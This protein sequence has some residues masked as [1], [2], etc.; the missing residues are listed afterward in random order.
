MSRKSSSNAA[1]KNSSALT[2]GSSSTTAQGSSILKSSF[3]PSQFQLRLFASVIQ[4]FDSQQLRIHETT[5]G[6]LRC[7][8]ET[9]P[10]SRITSLDW[11]FNGRDQKQKKKRKRQ[12]NSEGAVVAYGTSTSDIC[13]FSPAEGKV[14]GMLS[15]GHER[16]VADFKF[17]PATDYKEGWSVGEDAKLVQWDLSKNKAIRTISIPDGAHVLATPSPNPFQILCASDTPFAYDFVKDGNYQ[18][19]RFDSFKNPIHSLFR[20]GTNEDAQDEFFL[21]ADSDRYVNVFNL[22]NKRLAR[23]LIAGS[24]VLAADLYDPSEEV[25]PILREQLLTVVTEAGMV[26]L[27]WRPFSQ[28]KQ[29]NGDL[30]S[31][32]KNLTRKSGASIRLVSSDSKTRSVPIFAASIQG[33]EVV[34]A[35][36]DGGV[37][38]SFQKIRWQ[39]EGNGELL[40]DGA[41][42]FVKVKSASTL[43][44]ATL[45]GVKDTGKSHLDESKTVVVN[46]GSQPVTI[47]ISD[48]EK[49]EDGWGN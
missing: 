8:H 34:V 35:S 37:D 11:G 46:G 27:F 6:R 25:R 29:V 33:P 42:D 44:T 20:S 30:K 3:S 7:Q 47:D 48:S 36:A 21:A 19:S 41:K 22:Q 39:D 1:S 45:N 43:N 32:K 49:D 15:G 2:T 17:S 5:T 14:V 9:R 24:G 12:D 10:G 23:T 13:M 26:E 40:F 31:S 16:A 18:Q 28:P 4:S 38:F